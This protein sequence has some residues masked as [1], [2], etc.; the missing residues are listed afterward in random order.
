MW[1]PLHCSGIFSLYDAS[2]IML[3]TSYGPLHFMSSLL[4]PHALGRWRLDT[5][6]RSLTL[7]SMAHK[8]FL[9]YPLFIAVF[10]FSSAC[11]VISQLV[12]ICLAKSSATGM[13]L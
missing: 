5:R 8:C 4:N 12:C 1:C 2:P 9:L 13:V 7:Y 11:L 10:V 6:M 3:M